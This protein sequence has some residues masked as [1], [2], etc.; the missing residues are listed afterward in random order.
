V[1]DDHKLEALHRAKDFLGWAEGMLGGYSPS[2]IVD[3]YS[4]LMS[5]LAA[6]GLDVSDFNLPAECIDE[7]GRAYFTDF[8]PRVRGAMS[9]VERQIDRLSPENVG[10]HFAAPAPPIPQI[11]NGVF[12][13]HGQNQD[14]VDTI[15]GLLSATRLTPL[16]FSDVRGLAGKPLPYVGE[17][18][19]AAFT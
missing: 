8:A 7:S 6:L 13:V 2:N 1:T 16:L 18:L 15:K 4:R 9:Y 14:A 19:D 3:S 11:E 17:V 10:S 12:I 5:Q